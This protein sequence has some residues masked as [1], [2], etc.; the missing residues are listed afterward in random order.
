MASSI[1]LGE[2]PLQAPERPLLPEEGQDLKKP[3]GLQAPREGGPKGLGHLAELD[4]LLRGEAP[5]EGLE[6]GPGPLLLGP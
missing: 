6:G 2:G 1:P 5:E 4:P 3:R